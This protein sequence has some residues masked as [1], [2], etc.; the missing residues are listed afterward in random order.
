MSER[1]SMAMTVTKRR[2][3]ATRTIMVLRTS[4]K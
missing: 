1:C 3:V 4:S 2:Q